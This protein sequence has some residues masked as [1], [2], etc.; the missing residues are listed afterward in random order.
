[1]SPKPTTPGYHKGTNN[2]T[3]ITF[4]LS[5]KEQL[6]VI[7]D[8]QDYGICKAMISSKNEHGHWVSNSTRCKNYIDERN[9]SYC[10]QHKKHE[11]QTQQSSITNGKLSSIQQLRTQATLASSITKR[12]TNNMMS[13]HINNRVGTISQPLTATKYSTIDTH[14][15][16]TTSRT[17]QTVNPLSNSVQ[18]MQQQQLLRQKY[19]PA[20]QV[21]RS[22]NSLLLENTKSIIPESRQQTLRTTSIRSSNPYT[23]TKKVEIPSKMKNTKRPIDLQCGNNLLASINDLHQKKRKGITLETHNKKDGKMKRRVVVNID[24]D[25]FHGSVSIPKPSKLLFSQT[26][27]NIANGTHLFQQQERSLLHDQKGHINTVMSQQQI[28]A[29]KLKEGTTVA[30]TGNP[31]KLGIQKSSKKTVNTDDLFGSHFDSNGTVGDDIINMKSQFASEVEAEEHARSRRV[32]CELEEQE[33]KTS[34]HTTTNDKNTSH[35]DGNNPI[36][37]EWYCYTCKKCYT[38]HQPIRCIRLQHQIKVKR[39][40]KHSKSKADERLTLSEAKVEDG[41]LILSTGLD[42]SRFHK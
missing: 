3:S 12:N 33:Y 6:L 28:L 16:I 13:I 29:S 25:G 34:Y 42:W 10:K 14:N 20:N 17:T 7:G 40:I 39:D 8:A 21:S 1:M 19:T 32:L 4:S 35:D 31:Q 18:M 11:H 24:T 26:N 5:D 9:G 41:G 23:M 27:H 22:A 15:A 38:K 36:L 2:N 37:K 30:A